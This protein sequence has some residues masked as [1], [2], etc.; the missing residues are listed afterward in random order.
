[1]LSGPYSAVTAMI[2]VSGEAT[3]QAASHI[4]AVIESVVLG[5]TRR[6]FMVRMVYR[7]RRGWKRHARGGF[8]SVRNRF[9]RAAIRAY[10]IP[11]PASVPCRIRRRRSSEMKSRLAMMTRNDTPVV[12]VPSA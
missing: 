1:M 10:T 8:L 5:L 12:T 11:S 7:C 2:S 4:F 3:A 9:R 6:S